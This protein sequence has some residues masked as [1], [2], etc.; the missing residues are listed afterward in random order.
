MAM[1]E[2]VREEDPNL[3]LGVRPRWRRQINDLDGICIS[4]IEDL[5]DKEIQAIE[6]VIT[7]K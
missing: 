3:H 6:Q 1:V 2:V 4:S 7:F 5:A